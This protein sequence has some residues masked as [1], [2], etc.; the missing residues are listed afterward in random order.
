MYRYLLASTAVIAFAAPAAATDIATARTTSIKTSTVKNGTPDNVTITTAGSVVVSGGTAVTADDDHSVT[1]QG[2]I[3]IANANGS[4]GIAADADT[5]GDIVNS[6]TITVDEPYTPTDTDKDGD[7]DGPFALGSNR[8]GIRL[9][10]DHTGKL[11]NNG[12]IT[13]EGN[14][15]AGI[16]LGGALDGALTHNGTTTVIG[17]R[18]VGLDARA[19]TGDVR[20]AGTITVTGKDAVGARF[21]GDVSGAM[22]VQGT[23]SATGYRYVAPT[24]LTKLDADDILQGGSALMIEGNVGGGIILAVPPKDNNPD[25]K[26]EDGDGIEDSKEGSAK[27]VSYGAA[28]AMIVGATDHAIAIGPVASTGSHYGLQ[29]DGAVGG[30]GVIAEVN[31]TGLQIAGR[32]GNVAIANGI[33][34][35]GTISAISN[36][37]SATALLFG[38]GASTPEIANAGLISASGSN[39]STAFATGI[40]VDTGATVGTIRNSG[41]I[42]AAAGA[43]GNATAILDRSGGVTLVENSGSIEASGAKVDSIRNTAIDLSANGTGVTVRQTQVGSG[44]TAPMIAGDI[45]LGSGSDK[46][47]IADGTFKGAAYLGA[48]NDAYALSGDAIHT[49]SAGFGAGDDTMTLAG[50]SQFLGT[51]DFAGGGVDELSVGGSSVFKGTLMNSDSLAVSVAGGTL[52]IATPTTLGSLAV[53]AGGTLVV[54]LDKAANSGTAYTVAGTASFASGSKLA[55]RLANVHDAVGSYT[56]IDANSLQGASGIALNADTIPFMF[57][58]ALSAS[59]P[60]NQI[61][62]DVAKKSIQDLGLNRSQASAYDAIFAALAKDDKVDATFL[63]ITDGAIFRSTVGQMLPD[64][65]GGTFEGLSEGIRSFARL[66][67]E[68]ASPVYSSGSLN[69]VLGTSVWSANKSEG[70]TAAFNLDGMGFSGGADIGTSIGNFGATA[71]YL[72]S[73]YGGAK[74]NAAVVNSRAYELAAYWRAQWSGFSAFARGSVGTASF[75]GK[76]TFHG[77]YGDDAIERVSAA[78]R[79]G[80]LVSFSGGLSYEG[81]GTYVF[82]RPSASFDYLRLKEKGYVEAGGGSA[83]DLIVNPRTSDEIAVNGGLV[84]G[85]DFTGMRSRDENWFRIEAEGGWREIVGGELGSTTA[86]FAGGTDFTLLPEQQKSGWYGRLRALGGDSAFK[87]SGELSAERRLGGTALAM[88]G[89]IAIGF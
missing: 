70:E 35:T 29:I 65:A 57:K 69:I 89:G 80:S 33:G 61:R 11:T 31:A 76:R 50:S 49:G 51:A 17:D 7:L 68:P 2:K 21:A 28:P 84:L 4:I 3:A 53:G 1:N 82:F 23:V 14:D 34:N 87:I 56:V 72:W 18:A 43:N 62:I 48:G 5:T 67:S 63:G 73:S 83:L 47:S 71:T 58:A 41:A 46:L 79:N 64:H 88:R 36:G 81:G 59:A 40:L 45:R 8:F 22:V 27:I 13:V 74:S 38:Y 75:H 25:N 37:A 30:A 12:T 44:F 66:V 77:Q 52:D 85:I 20:L 10:G 26:D 15:S 19:I 42:K 24:D 32:G 39:A 16:Q 55:V 78:K 54:T 9:L 60:A 86:H 6:G